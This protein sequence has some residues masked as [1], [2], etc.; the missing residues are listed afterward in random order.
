MPR[1]TL[2]GLKIGQEKKSNLSAGEMGWKRENLSRQAPVQRSNVPAV[3]DAVKGKRT[4]WGE[5]GD[6]RMR[7]MY[8]SEGKRMPT[9]GS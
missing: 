9:S 7:A 5:H 4:P 3:G 6:T 2:E 8:S 1:N